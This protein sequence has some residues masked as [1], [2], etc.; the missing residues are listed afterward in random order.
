M[1]L[2]MIKMSDEETPKPPQTPP[3]KDEKKVVTHK[4]EIG[5][6]PEIDSLQE[7]LTRTKIELT[8]VKEGQ[9]G[10]KKKILDE[11]TQIEQELKEKKAILDKQALDTLEK[12]KESILDL[13]KKSNL[14]DEQITEI[15][16]K[17][18]KVE[19]V[20]IVKDMITMLVSAT[21]KPIPP[22]KTPSGKA[23]I[24]PPLKEGGTDE[25]DNQRA[26]VDELYRRA[27]YA[28]QEYTKE[29]IVDAKKKIETLLR[30]MIEGKSWQQ[31]KGGQ[32]LPAFKLMQCPKCSG[33]IVGEVPEKCPYCKF[34]FA[35]TGDR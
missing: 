5:R 32:R 10:E 16:A 30:S 9:E 23:P 15:E 34:N 3:E 33:T 1:L 8:K 21:E 12:E 17:L 13:A 35:K 7:E 29:E 28:P 22:A 14:S 26:M 18:T 6:Q 31:L 27:Y 19:N 24:T 11:K 25:F 4:V 20:S 2:K